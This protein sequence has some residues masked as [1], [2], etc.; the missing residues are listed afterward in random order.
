MI[1]KSR[2][3]QPEWYGEASTFLFD[4]RSSWCAFPKARYQAGSV[5]IMSL[6]MV[7]NLKIGGKPPKMDDENNG[8]AYETWDDLGGKPT[9][10][11]NIHIY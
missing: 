10:F 6:Y 5:C 2:F 8:K 11:G 7:G 4:L 3:I 1:I 9:I